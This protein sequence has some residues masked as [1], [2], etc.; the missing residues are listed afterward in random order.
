MHAFLGKPV[1][2]QTPARELEALGE[3]GRLMQSKAYL[4]SS[5]IF[6]ETTVARV[7][8]LMSVGFPEGKGSRP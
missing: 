3:A 5:D 1:T 6:H 2:P 7:Q 4:D 8:E